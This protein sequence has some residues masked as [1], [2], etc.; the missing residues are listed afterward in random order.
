MYHTAVLSPT[1]DLWVLIDP[2]NFIITGHRSV[3]CRV[4]HSATLTQRNTMHTRCPSEHVSS[5]VLNFDSVICGDPLPVGL[6]GTLVPGVGL[7][8]DV[9]LD[10][11]LPL[12]NCHHSPVLASLEVGTLEWNRL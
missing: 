4:S 3:G 8:V 7:V 2:R 6:L 5:T 1:A 11:E 9:D 12:P 10:V